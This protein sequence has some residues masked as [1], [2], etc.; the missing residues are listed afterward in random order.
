MRD[1]Q[2]DSYRAL[3]MI[4]ILCV[5]HVSYW[6]GLTPEPWRSVIL[7]EMPVIFFISGASLS[8]ASRQKTLFQTLVNRGKRVLAPYYIY[9]ILCFVFFLIITSLRPINGNVI[10]LKDVVGIIFPADRFIRVPYTTHLWFV[11]PYLLV[12]VVF[13]F[14]QKILDRV[15]RWYAAFALLGISILVD[16]IGKVLIT[17][18]YH[19]AV[20]QQVIMYNLFFCAG[21][22]FYKKLSRKSIFLIFAIS[23]F[24]LVVYRQLGGSVIPMQGHKFMAPDSVFLIYGIMALAF[25]GLV[26]SFVSVPSCRVLRHWNTCGYTIYL[27]QNVTF[28]ISAFILARL[29]SFFSIESNQLKFVLS[30]IIIFVKASLISVPTVWVENRVKRI[31]SVGIGQLRK[32]LVVLNKTLICR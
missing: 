24:A 31:V 29:Y 22:L 28:W 18:I 21:Y 8:V 11:I 30:G 16:V 20:F 25:W 15:N 4:Y 32:K 3:T 14:E 5:I 6:Y 19:C 12:Y 2:L 17:P 1:I 27:W 23:A 13:I 7:F 26:L 9:A 10:E